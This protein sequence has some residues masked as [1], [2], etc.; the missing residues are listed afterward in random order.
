MGFNP[1]REAETLDIMAA[2][3]LEPSLLTW[4]ALNFRVRL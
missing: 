3:D 2:T 1:G 4:T